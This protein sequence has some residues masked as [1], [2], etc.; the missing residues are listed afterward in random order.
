ML[1]GPPTGIGEM[2][3][4]LNEV[5]HVNNTMEDVGRLVDPEDLPDEEGSGNDAGQDISNGTQARNHEMDLNNT[6]EDGSAKKKFITSCPG[7]YG[8]SIGATKGS[9]ANNMTT[10]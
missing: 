2:L 7:T 8:G 5:F 3:N 1:D 4:A 10:W 9:S 6:L